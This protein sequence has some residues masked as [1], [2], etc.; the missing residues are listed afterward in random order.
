M[1]VKFSG[2]MVALVTPFQA[3]GEVDYNALENLVNMQ[4]EGGTHGLVICGTTG[5]AATMTS[6]EQDD[7]LSFVIK[8]VNGKIPVIAGTGSNNTR[9][10]VE[11]SKAAKELGADG[12]L[13]VTPPYN[14]PTQEGLVQYYETITNE[15]KWPVILYNVPGRT[16]INMLPSTVEKLADNP[17]VVAIKDATADLAVGSEI[18][19]RCGDRITLLSGDD[20]TAL[21]L[22]SIGG[23][24]WISVTANVFPKELVDMYQA[25]QDGE[26][27]KAQAIHYKFFPVHG[28]MF[29]QS[30]PIPCKATLSF[31]GKCEATVRSPLIT[32]TGDSLEK[33]RSDLQACGAL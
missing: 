27:S 9:V 15:V 28:L 32:M 7:V 17:H 25:W 31:L 16:S 11:R 3:D 13:V 23:E 5:E 1:T 30:N 10:A 21:P 33:L 29:C 12:L 19:Q 22:L 24:G 18:K 14:K 26:I 20:F 2:S 8:Q 6:K 4:L